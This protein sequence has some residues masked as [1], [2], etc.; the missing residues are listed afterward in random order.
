MTGKPIPSTPER[1]LALLKD[2]P[3]N[4]IA[5]PDAA[6][7]SVDDAYN[8]LTGLLSLDGQLRLHRVNVTLLRWLDRERSELVYF[9]RD[10]RADFPDLA[11]VLDE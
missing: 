11:G 7:P 4:I 10:G 8:A 3:M 9:D 2:S 6:A 1:G 5:L